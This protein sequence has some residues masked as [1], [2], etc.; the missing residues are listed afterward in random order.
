MLTINDFFSL[1]NQ[2]PWACVAILINLAVVFV[3]GYTDGPSTIATAVTSRALKPRTA[4]IMCAAFNLLGALAIGAFSVYISQVFGG[5]IVDTI[6]SLVDFGNAST[7][8]ILCAIA[9]G[10]A[11]IVVTSQICT[12]L[13]LPS[14]QSN[15]LIGG[16]TGGGLAL[17]T[18][19]FGGSIGIN[20]WIKVIIGFVGSLIVGFILGFGITKLIQLICRKMHAGKANRFFTHGQVVSCALMN[21]VHGIQ[22]GGKF[23][24]IS[25]LISA[26]LYKDAHSGVVLS[27]TVSAIN[28]TWWIYLPVC[29]VLFVACLVG[30][31][32][33]LKSLGRG[34]A[35]LN[36]YQAFATDIA[37]SIGLIVATLF[38]LPLSTGTIKNTAIMGTGAAKS[39]RRVKWKKAGEIVMWNA[40]AF[41]ISAITAF[42]LLMIFVWL[43]K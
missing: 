37:S 7:D 31:R 2:H 4:F 13:G 24:G 8:K 32:R 17:M 21:F 34:M 14:S 20:P 5:D 23:I 29:L 38:G 1:C 9:C 27:E 22:D 35:S 12:M 19:G 3:N 30:N 42:I 26:I 18:L 41:P 28:G 11:A 40:L 36:K 16:L 43:T 6:S 39:M 25:V 10:L 15:C 33:I